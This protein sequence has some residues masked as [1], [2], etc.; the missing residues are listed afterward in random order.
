MSGARL[1]IGAWIAGL[2]ACAII[3]A[4]TSFTADMSAFL[5]RAPSAEQR[6]LVDQLREG[7]VSRL[8][9]IGIEG[10]DPATRAKLSI[11]LAKEMRESKLF[12][13]VHNGDASESRGDREYVFA[14]RYLLSDTVTNDRFTVDGLRAA[15]NDSI[16]ALSSP[17]GMMLKAILPRD[18]TGE[19]MRLVDR[20]SGGSESRPRDFDGAW[21]SASG[22]RAILIAQ[23]KSAGSDIDGQQQ[24]IGLI[25]E[26]FARVRG[27]IGAGSNATTP[28]VIVSGNGAFAVSSRATIQRE[29]LRLSLLSAGLVIALLL[30][31]YRSVVALVLGLLPV[32]SGGIAAVAA[33]SAGFGYVH[34]LTLGFGTTLIGEAV[35]YSIYLFIQSERA[36]AD[37]NVGDRHWVERFWPTIRLGVLTSICGFASL[38]FSG[39]PGLAQ[40]GL[41]SITGLLVAA[42]VTRFVLPSLLPS[43][44][45]VRDV[46][47]L[48]H[49][50][51]HWAAIG[52]KGRWLL[53][54]LVAISVAVLVLHRSPLWNR[55][56]SA[57]SPVPASDLAQ[58]D[59]LRT[60]LGA[61]D[62]RF[63]V[64]ASGATED[65]ALEAAERAGRVLDTLVAEGA[66]GG[67]ESPAIFLPS[68]ATQAA[69]QQVLPDPAELKRRIDGA[70]ADLPLRAE[71][72]T[73]F[74]ADV[75]AARQRQPLVRADLEGTSLAEAVDALLM[76]Q[77]DRV[78]AVLPL[79]A[80]SAAAAPTAG[81]GVAARVSPGVSAGVGAGAGA[82]VGTSD[83]AT[84][85]PARVR[86]ALAA[87]GL[88]DALFVDVTTET[89]ALYAAYLRQAIHLSLAGLAAIAVLLLIA[90][91][92]VGRVVR[93]MT[94]LVAS[95]LVVVAGIVA[96]GYPL[97]IMHLVGMLLIVAIGSNYALFFDQRT[98][99][100][101]DDGSKARML[102]SLLCANLTTVAGFGLLA[103]SSVPVLKALGITVGPG[104]VLA[105]VFSAMLSS[106]VARAKGPR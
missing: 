96:L 44:F 18:P 61:P 30:V 88:P 87:A 31:I 56:L 36:R 103:F 90:L 81:I 59:M 105:L 47:S 62:S 15:I 25:E 4:Q 24:A 17:A 20:L 53:V 100:A 92:S 82:G 34:G 8:L 23:T 75:E 14:N 73:P 70:T 5:P 93:V 7:A 3:I 40:L 102:A 69:R 63:L 21:A 91:R 65:A 79:R 99:R 12:T 97:T 51:E 54:V 104:A 71:R 60:D 29:V 80:P 9:L 106:V 95:V 48:G 1:A 16:E 33:V 58:H 38:L 74:L 35:D 89:Q 43:T 26:R 72:L 22:E 50:V 41:Y 64:V 76:R 49:R 13:G 6:V 85:D 55:E 77:G 84:I 11:A 68:R 27:E 39:F 98:H 78:N 46:S 2:V 10:G 67:F 94:P 42:V 37:G 45:R 32:L 28:R 57:L 19:T 52:A 101:D 86:A 66:I 83:T